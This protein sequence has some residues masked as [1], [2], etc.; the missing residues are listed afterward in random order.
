MKKEKIKIYISKSSLIDENSSYFKEAVK[1]IN[2]HF[3]CKIS[4]WKKTELSYN[5]DKLDNSS[6]CIFLMDETGSSD[7]IGKGMYSE[8]QHCEHNNIPSIV[9]YLRRCDNELQF[10]E[11]GH[12]SIIN[13][14]NWRKYAR[15]N[16]GK[17]CTGEIINSFNSNSCNQ[18]ESFSFNEE[19]LLLLVNL[20]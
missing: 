1:F 4:F 15:I 19:E 18:K 20:N 5:I 2:E 7:I 16:F 10:Y 8:I 17:N 13:E 12:A 6:L 11:T 9:L 14:D 3:H